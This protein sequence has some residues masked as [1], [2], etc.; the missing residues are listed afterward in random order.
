MNLGE[1]IRTYR[2]EK[3]MT[4]EEMAGYLGVTAPAVNKWEKGNSF[5]DISLLAPIARLLGI[6]TDTLLSY[7]EELTDQEINRI[8]ERCCAMM[9]SEDYD[10]A[11]SWAINR[12]Q[13][14]PSCEK[15]ILTL[16]NVLDG[17]RTILAIDEPQRYAEK[18]R[19]LYTRLLSSKD[20]SIVQAAAQSLF[21]DALN[22]KEYENAQEYLNRIPEQGFNPR[23]GRAL[24]LQRKGD[25]EEAY[26]LYE[27]LVFQA[28]SEMSAA[29][30]GIFSMAFEEEDMDKAE[31]ILGK[32]KKLTQI[33]EMGRYMENSYELQLA[34]CRKD[35]DKTIE[36]LS[37]MA[38]SIRVMD[39][40]KESRLYEHMQFH[41]NRID[42]IVFMLKKGLEE[43]EKMDFA[44]EDA[45]YGEI[46]E[47]LNGM[48]GE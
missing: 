2:K 29:L 38:H 6:S 14:Y 20:N 24:L 18:I 32:Q 8:M 39:E 41:E 36:A 33:L 48:I 43:D 16:A 9:K 37:K 28:Y 10:A 46:M 21:Y 23:R 25:A 27:Q 35:R 15:L 17:Y 13:E 42:Y 31:Y 40:Y 3:Q 11:F 45:R 44:R 34:M 7:E 1:V 26:R 22:K 4:Q 12:L 30:T 5:P 47:E 19:N